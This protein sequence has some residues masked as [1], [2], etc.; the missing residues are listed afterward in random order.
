M[1]RQ[2]RAHHVPPELDV[3]RRELGAL[4]KDERVA[5]GDGA[6]RA[7]VYHL[8]AK[9]ALARY[10]RHAAVLPSLLAPH[11]VMVTGP[12]PVFAFAPELF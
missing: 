6:I 3:I 7:V 10:R 1:A 8:V 9:R 5:R 4:V 12:W 11:T 2:E